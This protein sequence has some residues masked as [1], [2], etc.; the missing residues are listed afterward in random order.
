M[1]RSAKM[2]LKMLWGFLYLRMLEPER[3][4]MCPS[5]SEK[6]LQLFP[7]KRKKISCPSSKQR[8]IS[9]LKMIQEIMTPCCVPLMKTQ[10]KVSCPSNNHQFQPIRIS[11]IW[12]WLGNTYNPSNTRYPKKKEYFSRQTLTKSSS[13]TTKI[14]DFLLTQF[15]LLLCAYLD[16]CLYER[17]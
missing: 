13:S 8:M 15:D 3:D 6:N 14:N 9:K 16:S 2:L 7:I 12:L 11:L 17:C 10:M 5:S 4:S 1:S